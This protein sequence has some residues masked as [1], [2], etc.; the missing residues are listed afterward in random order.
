MLHA[1]FSAVRSAGIPA[2]LRELLDLHAAMQHNLA[3]CDTTAFYRLSRT[4]LVKD[5][6][7]YDRFDRVFTAFFEGVVSVDAGLDAGIPEDWLTSLMAREFSEEEKRRILAEGGFEALLQALRERMAQ[8]SHRH[9]GGNRMIGTRGT[10]P[11]GADGYHPEGIRIGQPQGRHNRAVKIWEQR[12]FRDLDDTLTLGIRDLQMALRRLRQFVREGENEELDLDTTIQQT[13]RNGGL[14][15]IRMLRERHNAVKVLL[16]LD[17][18]GSMDP[19]VR[20]CEALFS[21]ARTEFKYLEAFYFHNFI[22]ESVWRDNRR[23]HQERTPLVDILHRFKPDYRVIFVGDATMSPYEITR[24]GGSIEHWNEAPGAWWMQQ[25][26]GHFARVAW[27]NPLSPA[28]WDYGA[29]VSLTRDL[30]AGHMY[31]LSLA[32][33]EQAMRYL[34]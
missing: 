20:T 19:H 6:K 24:I 11:F 8:Q 18:G 33:L 17:V 30:V 3:F 10:S 32:G 7:Y 16:F 9:E 15:D 2:T 25:V 31:P 1:F 27:L 23:R 5:E 14:L 22:Y 4:C 21:A 28:A 26:T 34:T 12:Q 29:S 13:A